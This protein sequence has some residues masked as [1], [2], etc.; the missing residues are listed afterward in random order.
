[1]T[2]DHVRGFDPMVV[3]S[4]LFAERHPGVSISWEKRSLQAFADQP[5]GTMSEAYDLMVIDHPHVGDAAFEGDLLALDVDVAALLPADE[6]SQGFDNITV[7]D[8]SPTL[9]NRYVAAAQKISRMAVGDLFGSV[10]S[11]LGIDATRRFA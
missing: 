2:W 3:T 9:L 4:E 1:M 10:V 11:G 8:L 6:S 5:L 7:A